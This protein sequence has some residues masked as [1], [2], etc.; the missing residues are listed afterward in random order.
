MEA[1]ASEGR[2]WLITGTS[3]GFGRSLAEE[4]LR[5][6]DR[7]VATARDP[8]SVAD[9]VE[10]APERVL[11]VRLDVV[12]EAT[13]EPA[14][15]AALARFGRIDVLVNNA[16]YGSVGAVEETPMAELRA[17]M[18]V[19]FFGAVAVT[20]AVLPAMRAQRSGAIVQISSMGGQLSFAGFGAYSA[21]KFA[22]EGLSEALAAELGPLGVQV[23]IVEPG[24][25]RTRFGGAALRAMPAID[26]YAGTVGATRSFAAGMDGTQEGDPD[27]AAAAICDA[28][29]K[30]DAPM[31]LALGK[32]A[33]DALR[34]KYARERE[35]LE[36]WAHVGTAMALD[37]KRG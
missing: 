30:S 25:F 32:D 1:K 2:V 31:R 5:R 4:A 21:S 8:G 33:V 23:L 17:Q 6:G 34:A 13:I 15:A 20:R 24:A 36:A 14:V 26:D 22:L 3:S 35:E 18:E 19:N 28:I 11:A 9:L 16:G 27:K 7:V 10:K 37:A 12:D 29:G